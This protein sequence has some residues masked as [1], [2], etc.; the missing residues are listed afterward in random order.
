VKTSAVLTLHN[1]PFMGANATGRLSAYDLP[2]RRL[3]LPDWAVALPLPLGLWAADA[4]VAVSPTYA[5][6]ILTP[7]HGCGLHDFLRRRREAISGILNGLDVQAYDPET[8]SALEARFNFES[9][10][11]RLE[12]K[13]A[14]QE[15]LGLPKAPSAPLLGMVTRLE[16][17]K[18]V[19][20]ALEALSTLADLPW[21]AV[22][23]GRGDQDLERD[24]C[25][26]QMD[27]RERVR[28]EIRFDA[29]LARQIYG[30]ADIFLMPSRYEP[31]GMAQMIAM[32]YG[33]VPVVRAVGGLKDT[34]QGG[35]T[36]FLFEEATV[37]SLAEIIRTALQ[38]Y[39]DGEQW[40][41]L[42]RNGMAQDFSWTRSAKQ[43]FDLYRALILAQEKTR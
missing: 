1:L 18:G 10:A 6:E 38:A 9:L 4:I 34:V 42:Q 41:R 14:L 13:I 11:S 15:R 27:M 35:Q 31:C 32:R 37:E 23:L 16:P 17:Q 7:E 22:I 5:Q 30:G 3:E 21:Q 8:D 28:A 36:G 24:A 26:L 43:Y 39:A 12:N 40:R 29:Q 25:C 19:D 2:L 33:C 20:L